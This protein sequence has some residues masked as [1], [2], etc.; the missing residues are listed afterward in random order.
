MLEQL[1]SLEV[2]KLAKEK[3]FKEKTYTAY[4]D[5]GSIIVL[6]DTKRDL[7][8]INHNNSI[9]G[10]SAP[11]QALLAKWLREEKGFHVVI[12]PTVESGWT[13]KT[14]RVLSKMDD[15]VIKGLASVDSLP[16]YKDVHA[17]DYNSYEEALENA[18][19]E[20]LKQL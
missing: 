10:I 6:K 4:K 2:A 17:W 9:Y 1:V 3:G 20:I 11:T 18:F 14:V 19:I 15:D 12:I 7:K 5:N 13:Y 8:F 16:P